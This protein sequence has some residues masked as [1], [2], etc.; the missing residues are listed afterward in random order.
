MPVE[1]EQEQEIRTAIKVAVLAGSKPA[2]EVWSSVALQVGCTRGEVRIVCN[3]LMS[4]G[5]LEWCGD[6]NLQVPKHRRQQIAETLA[7]S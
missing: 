1:A 3:A 6:M 2:G 7:P 4:D 5:Y